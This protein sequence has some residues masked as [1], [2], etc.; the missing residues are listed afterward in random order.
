MSP[1]PPGRAC[2]G[3]LRYVLVVFMGLAAV[4]LFLLATAAAN[5]TV[6]AEQYR[7][8]D[9]RHCVADA[10][11]ARDLLGWEASISLE[12]GIGELARWVEKQT[13]AD[14]VESAA[15]ELAARGLAR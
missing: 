5:T 14:R 12:Q 9:I 8:G 10:K 13:A 3:W 2:P 11:L 15:Q 6:F 7:A 4:T 1:P